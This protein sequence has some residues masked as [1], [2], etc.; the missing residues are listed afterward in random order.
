MTKLEEQAAV[1]APPATEEIAGELVTVREYSWADALRAAPIARPIV[2][3]FRALFERLGPDNEVEME[4]LEAVFSAHADAFLELVAIATDR[5][6]H[7]LAELPS[8]DGLVLMYQFWNCN[9]HFFTGRLRLA[10]LE[11]RHC[12]PPNSLVH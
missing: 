11:R 1:L 8:E 3:E 12:R 9:Q 2:D 10:M 4:D 5:P 7:W 6:V